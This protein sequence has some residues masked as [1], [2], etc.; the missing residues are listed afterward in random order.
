MGDASSTSV[1]SKIEL[2]TLMPTAEGVGQKRASTIIFVLVVALLVVLI[3]ASTRSSLPE[4]PNNTSTESGGATYAINGMT[5]PIPADYLSFTSVV[6][7][8]PLVTQNSQFVG[9][10]SGSRYLFGNAE[11]ITA[12]T[13][14]TGNQPPQHLPDVLEMVFYY[15][16]PGTNCGMNQ[17][18]TNRAQS[19]IVV[20]V[21]VENGT[22]DLAGATYHLSPPGP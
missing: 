16:G 11:N 14:Q 2:S 21:P 15:F 12:R 9:L 8:L 18:V 4:G 22:F 3:G 6:H 10:T 13:E 20:Q 1:S 19:V 5:C 7:L 17:T